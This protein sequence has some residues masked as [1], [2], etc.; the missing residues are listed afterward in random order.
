MLMLLCRVVATHLGAVDAV[1]TVS[2]ATQTVR[3]V[4]R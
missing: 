2:P 4:I 3:I 1:L